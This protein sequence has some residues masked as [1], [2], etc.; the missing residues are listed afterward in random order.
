MTNQ[1]DNEVREQLVIQ[2]LMRD[3]DGRKW[4]MK[5]LKKGKLFDS[6]FDSDPT[7][8]AHTAGMREMAVTLNREVSTADPNNYIK[9][10]K[11]S[12]DA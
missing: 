3:E 12:I 8:H 2:N 1:D 9:M 4:I 5:H 7:K 6:T 11:E 10:I